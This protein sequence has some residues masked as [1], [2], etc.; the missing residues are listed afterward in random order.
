MLYVDYRMIS[1]FT[2]VN[3]KQYEYKINLKQQ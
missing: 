2:K 3:I 1:L